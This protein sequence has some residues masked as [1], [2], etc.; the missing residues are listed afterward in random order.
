[1]EETPAPGSG[2]AGTDIVADRSEV[3]FHSVG[4]YLA[5][6]SILFDTLEIAIDDKAGEAYGIVNMRGMASTAAW[7]KTEASLEDTIKTVN[8]RG[9]LDL[10]H[11][12]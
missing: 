1:M 12:R 9:M 5:P 3:Q 4:I 7:T 11:F 10:T 8:R 2:G 6:D